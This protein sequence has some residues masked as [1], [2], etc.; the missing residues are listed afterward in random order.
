MAVTAAES[1]LQD[2]KAEEEQVRGLRQPW[3]EGRRLKL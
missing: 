3:Q 2:L 1:W